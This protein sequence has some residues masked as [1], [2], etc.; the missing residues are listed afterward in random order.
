VAVDLNALLDP[1]VSHGLALGVFD[2]VNM[3]EPESVPGIGMTMACWLDAGTPVPAGSGLAATTMRIALVVRV[4][5]NLLT[6]APDTID[7]AMMDAVSVLLDAYTGD[8]EFDGAVRAIDL[9]GMYGEPMSFRAGY[10]PQGDANFR[11][12]T[13]V[14]PLIV[15]DVWTQ[16]P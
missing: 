10:L 7:P 5:K 2:R 12:I 8:F 16:A 13:I 11:V 9:L 6:E 15:D 4:F 14:V 3:H 1:V